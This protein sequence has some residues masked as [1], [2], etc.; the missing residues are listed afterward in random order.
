MM[1]VTLQALQT[2]ILR[3]EAHL[4]ETNRK[5]EKAMALIARLS[6]Q[7][8]SEEQQSYRVDCMGDIP[9]ATAARLF[10]CSER[11]MRRLAEKYSFPSF[12]LG[13]DRQYYFMP[14]LCAIK[15]HRISHDEKVRKALDPK[16]RFSEI[17]DDV[18]PS[19]FIGNDC[20]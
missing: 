3:V 15:S 11:H 6:Y 17:P 4:S 10:C 1:N 18:Q 16:D 13:K 8:S 5:L 19:Q 7:S 9:L 2:D 12:K 20:K 14:L